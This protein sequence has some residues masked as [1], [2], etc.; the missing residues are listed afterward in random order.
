M[1]RFR[2]SVC[3][4]QSNSPLRENDLFQLDSHEHHKANVEDR[5]ERRSWRAGLN[6]AGA[7]A[8][9]LM[10]C[11]A[12]QFRHGSAT[13]YQ[14]Q[15][16][17]RLAQLAVRLRHIGLLAAHAVGVWVSPCCQPQQRQGHLVNA[18]VADDGTACRPYLPPGAAADAAV[19]LGYALRRDGTPTKLLRQRVAAGVTLFD[20]ASL[21]S[22]ASLRACCTLP[23][24]VLTCPRPAA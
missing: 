2:S 13:L 14:G 19:V 22:P 12:E 3:R 18:R 16:R 10:L 6:V 8:S 11:S 4:W 5:H 17:G 15:L 23:A 1:Q 21:A 9:M 20:R 24:T 7:H